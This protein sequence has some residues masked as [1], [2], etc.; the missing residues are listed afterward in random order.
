MTDNAQQF[1]TP[2]TMQAVSGQPVRG[3]L[4]DPA[5]EAAMGHI[6]LARWADLILVAPASADF[7]SRLASGR[8]NDLLTTLCLAT[9]APIALAPAMNQVMW[10]NTLTQKNVQA[11]RKQDVQ[12]FGPAE[13]SQAC[14]EVGPGRMLEP[15]EIVKAASALFKTGDL[16]GL[17]VLITAGPTQEAIDPVRYLTNASS[18]KMG[19]ALAGEWAGEPQ[20]PA[21]GQSR[22][23]QIN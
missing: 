18:G 3:N 22:A 23:D 16:A 12:I 1:I 20:F 21:A 6:E 8:A 9:Q 7:I 10:K 5:A 17:R 15:L 2:L 19:Y 14:G 11:L 4:F 13:G